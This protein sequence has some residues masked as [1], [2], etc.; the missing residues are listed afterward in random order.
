M[1]GSREEKDLKDLRDVKDLKD[2][3]RKFDPEV[4]LVPYVL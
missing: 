4:L 1:A 3:L 2:R